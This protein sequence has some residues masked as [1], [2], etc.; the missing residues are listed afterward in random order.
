MDL[1]FGEWG[2]IVIS[3]AILHRSIVILMTVACA[4]DP[5]SDETQLLSNKGCVFK[6]LQGGRTPQLVPFRDG[7]KD[8]AMLAAVGARTR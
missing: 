1:S 5:R 6:R 3:A 2:C 8:Q 4:D 7:S